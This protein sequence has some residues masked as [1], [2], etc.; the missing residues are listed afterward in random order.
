MSSASSSS[1]SKRSARPI[2]D[3]ENQSIS[4]SSS[5]ETG[6]R[7]SAKFS[8]NS[9]LS[10]AIHPPSKSSSCNFRTATC[11]VELPPTPVT[12]GLDLF[13]AADG[14]VPS[15]AQLNI[16]LPLTPTSSGF[17][18]SPAS[19]LLNTVQL[20][21][22]SQLG[23]ALPPPPPQIDAAAIEAQLRNLLIAP[24]APKL[25]S[26][27]SGVFSP[28]PSSSSL[29]DMM[30]AFPPTLSD[31]DESMLDILHDDIDEDDDEH[32]AQTPM[33]SLGMARSSGFSMQRESTVELIS[34]T[35]QLEMQTAFQRRRDQ[36][37]GTALLTFGSAAMD[38]GKGVMRYDD[39]LERAISPVSSLALTSHFSQ[40]DLL[41]QP[42]PF[43]PDNGLGLTLGPVT[44][45]EV[46]SILLEAKDGMPLVKGLT[47]LG[48]SLQ[49]EPLRS[50]LTQPTLAPPGQIRP[51][52]SLPK[53][54]S[55]KSSVADDL[56]IA[57]PWRE[58]MEHSHAARALPLSES[59]RSSTA[60][61]TP[62]SVVAVN[63][64]RIFGG[65]T[66]TNS[67]TTKVGTPTS[68]SKRSATAAALSSHLQQSVAGGKENQD[69]LVSSGSS[70]SGS[71]LRLKASA[72][73][74]EN[75]PTPPPSSNSS[76]VHAY[77]ARK[78]S[79][80]ALR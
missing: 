75:I 69:P 28:F 3:K 21:Q 14:K 78:R 53:K 80:V 63:K 29:A 51:T 59:R 61:A 41:D 67:P 46:A 77:S 66:P 70:G 20:P 45:Q 22:E 4:R 52:A 79:R 58:V 47:G 17:P 31:A 1:P 72:S 2:A 43:Q 39:D 24:G 34:T 57:S 5:T 6:F 44:V 71:G 11:N 76:V 74:N 19:S 27:E 49:G 23:I 48:I 64:P 42:L 33:K 15:P 32:E 36:G 40:L 10:I 13:P 25:G 7:P 16:E 30:P 26:R 56:S 18:S 62:L 38:K 55:R 35:A 68:P 60:T 9:S 73:E 54:K 37:N 8:S 65:L 50:A 12:A